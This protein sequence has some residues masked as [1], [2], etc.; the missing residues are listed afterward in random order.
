MRITLK[1]IK[2]PDFLIPA[3]LFICVF[4]AWCL[5]WFLL[6]D[7]IQNR[8][9]FG[10]MFGAVNALF[11]GLAFAGVIYAILL[12]RKELSLQRKELELTRQEL[13]GQKEQLKAQNETLIKQNFESTFFQLIRVFND[14]TNSIDLRSKD[15]ITTGKD[16]FN[17]FNRRLYH[18]WNVVLRDAKTNDQTKLIDD[19]YKDFY[20]SL[21]HELGHYFRTLY[22]VVKFVD[23]SD[24]NNKKFYT[25]II[26]AQLSSVEL[27]I[28]FYN[29]LSEMGREK[30]KP[31]VEEYALL[32]HV[33]KANLFDT[34][35][36]LALY[37]SR[38]YGVT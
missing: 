6:V 25:N 31:L 37:E 28:L 8:G 10:D 24:I 13:A 30:F 26:R 9:T 12:Q 2:N 32:K 19:A 1:N 21:Q 5:T 17:T 27:V 11:S 38:A 20:D 35:K 14:L 16:C 18:S 36:H 29:C 23:Q 34:G 15:R 22:N 33:P 4:T 3:C 7:D